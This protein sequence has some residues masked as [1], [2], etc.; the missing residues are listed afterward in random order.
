M[1]LSVELLG[2]KWGLPIAIAPMSAAISTV[3]K[4]AFIEM[5]K[6][7]KASG[8]AASIGYPVGPDTHVKMLKTGA[9]IFRIIKPL[10]DFGKLVESLKNS[11][12]NGCFATG[13]D[14]D[15][16]AG[17]KPGGDSGH[18]DDVCA[19]LSI[20]R[21]KEARKAVDIPFIIK[22]IVTVEDPW[23]P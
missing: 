15:S 7:A 8:I 5:A 21:L 19:P 23:P 17:L 16:V 1:D 6:G 18:F 20:E 22:G 4:D 13:V 14:T 12:K 10:R 11:E 2:T 3:C 9:P